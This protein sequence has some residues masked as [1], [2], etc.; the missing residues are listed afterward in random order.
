MGCFPEIDMD[1]VLP[2]NANLFTQS[3][4]HRNRQVHG[5][6]KQPTLYLPSDM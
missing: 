5:F 6:R 4:P 3:P 2:E 1:S